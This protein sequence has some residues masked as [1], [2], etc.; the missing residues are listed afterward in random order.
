M[1]SRRA[2]RQQA[3]KEETTKTE[4]KDAPR[5]LWCVHCRVSWSYRV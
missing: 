1:L 5:G 3:D 2:L 4:Q